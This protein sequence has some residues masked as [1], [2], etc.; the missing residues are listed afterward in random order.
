M[1][2]IDFN[3]DLSSGSKASAFFS[4]TIDSS[5]TRLAMALWS[6][7]FH[8]SSSP[9]SF[10]YGTISGG[11]SRPS[12]IITRNSPMIAASMS[13]SVNVPAASASS[14]G[15]RYWS[16]NWLMPAFTDPAAPSA[17]VR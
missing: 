7:I 10:E 11:S 9:F 1:T 14:T 16:R 4:R 17:K 3:F 2:A 8:A 13:A 12:R 6:P 5:T 15:L